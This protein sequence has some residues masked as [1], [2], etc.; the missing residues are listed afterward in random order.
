MPARRVMAED[1]AGRSTT[2]CPKRGRGA[3]DT[4][5]SRDL[6]SPMHRSLPPLPLIAAGR[7]YGLPLSAGEVADPSSRLGCQVLLTPE[8][9]GMVARLPAATR[10]MYVDGELADM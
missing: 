6:L 9:D 1:E 2:H 10:N 8:L 4:G 7:P 5:D 3:R